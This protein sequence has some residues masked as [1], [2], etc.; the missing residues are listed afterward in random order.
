MDFVWVLVVPVTPADLLLETKALSLTWPQ[1]KRMGFGIL[2]NRYVAATLRELGCRLS[3]LRFCIRYGRQFSSIA[4]RLRMRIQD[5]VGLYTLT[6]V[7]HRGM[8]YDNDEYFVGEAAAWSIE[9]HRLA[10][11]TPGKMN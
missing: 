10:L 5:I 11:L 9:A 6:K 3:L 1:A 2:F 8:L 4:F 7:L